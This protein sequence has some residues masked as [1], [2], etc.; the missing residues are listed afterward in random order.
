MEK[1]K[2]K[3]LKNKNLKNRKKR[4]PPPLREKKCRKEKPSKPNF[5]KISFWGGPPLEFEKK[6]M[7]FF[8]KKNVNSQYG[9]GKLG[10][11]SPPPQKVSPL[12][13]AITTPKFSF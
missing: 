2:M 3:K 7:I 1:K 6:K 8:N 10:I 12:K 9:P 5:L 4:A 13:K 11:K